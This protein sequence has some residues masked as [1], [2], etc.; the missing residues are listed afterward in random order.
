MGRSI[1]H[2]LLGTSKLRTMFVYMSSVLKGT[3][4]YWTYCQILPGGE[5]AN[6]RTGFSRYWRSE[7]WVSEA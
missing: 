3:Y 7:G 6:E 4:H 1:S 2:P 5:K